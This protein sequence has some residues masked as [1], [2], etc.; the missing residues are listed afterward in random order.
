MSLS[1]SVDLVR[2]PPTLIPNSLTLENYRFVL[3]PTGVADGQGSVQ[4]TRVPLRDLEQP[5]RRRLRHRRST[6]F[7]ARSPATPMRG[8]A[9]AG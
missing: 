9:R 4:A 2:T 1:P 5:G 6:W 8:T 3:F 7:S